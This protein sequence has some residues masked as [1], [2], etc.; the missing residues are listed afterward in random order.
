MHTHLFG[1]P[2]IL[3]A[4]S[5]ALRHRITPVLPVRRTLVAYSPLYCS[6][7]HKLTKKGA[8]SSSEDESAPCVGTIPG[9]KMN[10]SLRQP[11][12][13]FCRTR[14]FASPDYSGFALS[15]NLFFSYIKRPN[16]KQQFFSTIFLVL[17]DVLLFSRFEK[18]PTDGV[19]FLLKGNH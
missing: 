19:T 17:E 10:S 18:L 9:A 1:N 4:G 2:A 12:Y 13:P 14:G 6:S 15:E 11:G 3:F 7:Q 8:L 16:K 5:V